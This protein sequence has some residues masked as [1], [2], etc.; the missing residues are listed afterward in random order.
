M[1]DSR[2]GGFSYPDSP[3]FLDLFAVD[4]ENVSF[5]A[6]TDSFCADRSDPASGMSVNICPF[7]S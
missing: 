4:F 7:N 1:V 2:P 6:K 5:H 3:T